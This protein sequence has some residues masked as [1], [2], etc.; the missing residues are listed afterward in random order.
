M[1]YQFITLI[2]AFFTIAMVNIDQDEV[3]LPSSNEASGAMT[4]D[5]TYEPS[6]VAFDSIGYR[7]LQSKC[8]VCHSTLGKTHEELVA[9]PIFAV[10]TRYSKAHTDRESFVN[11]IV[12]WAK[13]PKEENAIMRGAVDNFKLMPYMSS[14]EDDLEKIAVFLYEN[15]MEKPVW[16]EEECKGK[17]SKC[18]KQSKDQ[19]RQ[20]K[21][22]KSNKQKCCQST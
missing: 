12:E 22:R 19:K 9:P 15:E 16:C 14:E 17:Q 4:E 8:M 10:K 11:S 6:P 1:K 13:E 3:V 18:N 20:R 21:G 2:A 5:M 7:L